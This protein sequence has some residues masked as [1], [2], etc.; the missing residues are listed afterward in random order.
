MELRKP[1]DADQHDCVVA[2]DVYV[3]YHGF[4]ISQLPA[5]HIDGRGVLLDGHL[6]S[7]STNPYLEVRLD[8]A[9][10]G[11]IEV[12]RLPVYVGQVSISRTELL[13]SDLN[14]EALQKVQ[15]AIKTAVAP[16]VIKL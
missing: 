12:H 13:F 10:H 11:K 4:L 14:E 9:C 8:I 1:V 16:Q 3:Y 6:N 15:V 7:P 2:S 5:V